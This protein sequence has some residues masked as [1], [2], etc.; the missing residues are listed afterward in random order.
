MDAPPRIHSC[1]GIAVLHT[2]YFQRVCI[3]VLVFIRNA[4]R[5]ASA[6]LYII[7]CH[8]WPV[9]PYHIFPRLIK[10]LELRRKNY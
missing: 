8:L 10:R 7:Y 6:A 5:N 2:T 3:L 1:R 4:M 9:W